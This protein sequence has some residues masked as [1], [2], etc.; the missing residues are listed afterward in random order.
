MV[1]HL[2]FPFLISV[3]TMSVFLVSVWFVLVFVMSVSRDLLSFV[4]LLF[5]EFLRVV[6]PNSCS[7]FAKRL[8]ES[9]L[10]VAAWL[11]LKK[12]PNYCTWKILAFIMKKAGRDLVSLFTLP[13]PLPPLLW[14]PTTLIFIIS[15][16]SIKQI[17]GS[18]IEISNKDK[19]R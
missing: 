7:Y 5:R 11:A 18:F 3:I 15:L 14:N 19:I 2:R 16:L 17:Q 13:T 12:R 1:K 9:Q 10:F 8:L 6:L 4:A